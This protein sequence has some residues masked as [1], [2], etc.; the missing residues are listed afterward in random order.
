MGLLAFTEF[1]K[2]C[3]HENHTVVPYMVHDRA[4]SSLCNLIYDPYYWYEVIG[5]AR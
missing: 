5:Y 2:A 4:F 3:M 1:C